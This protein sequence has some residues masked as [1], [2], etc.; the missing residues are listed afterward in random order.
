MNT[1][2][3]ISKN[4]RNDMGAI[5]KIASSYFHCCR[6]Q[7]DRDDL[8]GEVALGWAEGL[9]R[10][11]DTKT[12]KEKVSFCW[13]YAKGYA[14]NWFRGR[15]RHSSRESV[16]NDEER[17]VGDFEDTDHQ[18]FFEKLTVVQVLDAI[19]TLPEK[20]RDVMVGLFHHGQSMQEV[21]D[22]LGISRQRVCQIKDRSINKIRP[23]F[24]EDDR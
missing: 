24:Q 22:D 23:L 14:K 3:N 12:E 6:T 4:D 2:T 16:L 18:D 5:I 15:D 10:L 13:T 17:D 20:E 7:A 11:D 9:S 8:I 1:D 19:M 21:A